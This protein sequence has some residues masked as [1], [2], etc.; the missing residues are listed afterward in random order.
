MNHSDTLQLQ[1]KQL[2]RQ[3]DLIKEEMRLQFNLLNKR[4]G[5]EITCPFCGESIA[6]IRVEKSFYD[7]DRGYL[8]RKQ[9]GKCT[10]CGKWIKMRRIVDE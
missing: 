6:Q 2:E 7:K 8:V 1:I 3:L 4:L 10:R 9:A 5:N